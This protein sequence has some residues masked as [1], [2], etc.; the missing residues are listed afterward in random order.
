MHTHK[1]IHNILYHLTKLYNNI[2]FDIHI[3][4]AYG[5]YEVKIHILLYLT[6]AELS[7]ANKMSRIASSEYHEPSRVERIT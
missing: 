5:T 3:Y 4:I 2:L 7:P 1:I 6:R